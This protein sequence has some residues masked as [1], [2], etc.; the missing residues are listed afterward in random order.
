M[1]VGWAYDE[2]DE[3]WYHAAEDGGRQRVAPCRGAWYWFD[4]NIRNNRHR[5]R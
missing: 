3:C 4:S 1:A 5:T 2:N